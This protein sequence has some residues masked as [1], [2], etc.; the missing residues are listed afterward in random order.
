MN[1]GTWV[2]VGIGAGAALGVALD[3]TAMGVAF[4]AGIGVALGALFSK[5]R[6]SDNS[7]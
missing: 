5:R 1:T 4:G 2:A 7:D 3:Q 6:N